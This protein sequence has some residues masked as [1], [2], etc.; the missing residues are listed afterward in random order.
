VVR[1]RYVCTSAAEAVRAHNGYPR[2]PSVPGVQRVS[3]AE[4]FCWRNF[5]FGNNTV[6]YAVRRFGWGPVVG[7][8]EWPRVG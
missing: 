2:A 5:C 8:V 4:S 1:W 3:I 6:H 7:R